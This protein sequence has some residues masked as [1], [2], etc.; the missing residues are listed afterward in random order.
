MTLGLDY[1]RIRW[2]IASWLTLSTILNLIDRQTLSILAP[3]LREKF[4]MG[5]QGYANVVTVFQISYTV[6]YTVGGRFVDRIGERIGMAACIFWWSRCTILT[7]FTQGALS[8]GIVRFL[9]G[10]GEPGNYPAALR[11]TTRWFPKA[12]RGLP[13]ALF[14]SGSAIGNVIAP[15]LVAGLTLVYGWRAAFVLPGILGLLWLSGWLAIYRAPAEY[16][17]ITRDEL[18]RLQGHT[19]HPPRPPRPPPP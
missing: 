13:I 12:E 17:G 1:R 6:M 15:P 14:S 2:V 18:N 16:P 7:A 3:V 11:A 5:V 9:L 19:G 4:N 10:L 8:L